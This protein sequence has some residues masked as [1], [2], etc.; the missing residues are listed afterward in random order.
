MHI[1]YKVYMYLSTDE[2]KLILVKL[3]S[4]SQETMSGRHC[5]R[6]QA[7]L[8]EENKCQSWGLFLGKCYTRE[9]LPGNHFGDI[10]VKRSSLELLRV[11]FSNHQKLSCL[12]ITLE[13]YTHNAPCRRCQGHW[14]EWGTMG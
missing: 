13:R 1:I 4:L 6:Q 7:P 5:C 9:L 14:L 3:G 2:Y 12:W 11:H 10:K 8:F